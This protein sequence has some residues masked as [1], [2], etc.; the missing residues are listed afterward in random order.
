MRTASIIIAALFFLAALVFCTNPDALASATL[1]A[2]CGMLF[3]S[4]TA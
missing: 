3:G 2:Y 4:A 1:A